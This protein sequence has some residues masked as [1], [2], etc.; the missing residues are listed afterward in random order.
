[1]Q[2]QTFREFLK[3]EL[4]DYLSDIANHGCSGGFPHLTYY[5]DTVAL[6]EK[7]NEELFEELAQMADN[8]GQNVPELIASFN[9]GAHANNYHTFANLI[10]WAV[11]EEIARQETEKLGLE[12]E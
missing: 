12:S 2:T 4:A 5:K 8:M 11:A 1:M 9:G 7:H 10:V 6:F 3:T